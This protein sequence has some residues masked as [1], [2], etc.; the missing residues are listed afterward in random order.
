MERRPLDCVDDLE[1]LAKEHGWPPPTEF[2]RW[3]ARR[4][5][6]YHA[7]A[8]NRVSNLEAE[9][10]KVIK[11]TEKYHEILLHPKTGMIVQQD[12]IVD[13]ISWTR[14]TI[15]WVGMLLGVLTV[16]LH[17]SSSLMEIAKGS[18]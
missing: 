6:K 2:Q 9:L 8:M 1:Q 14:K 12:K 7:E 17:F 10:E 18:M 5:A 15:V 4:A 11:R 13:R 16:L 3:F